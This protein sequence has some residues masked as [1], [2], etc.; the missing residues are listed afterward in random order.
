MG[1]D[2]VENWS[3]GVITALL[4]DRLPDGAAF[5]A[6]N[7]QFRYTGPNNTVFGTRS[8]CS[9]Q[10]GTILA[11]PASSQHFLPLSSGD[12]FHL[13][14]LSNGAVGEMMLKLPPQAASLNRM[15]LS[16]GRTLT[17]LRSSPTVPTSSKQTA[18]I[19]LVSAS[20]NRIVVIGASVR[21]AAVVC[22]RWIPMTLPSAT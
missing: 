13:L 3:Q 6:K 8:G 1:S 17:T 22:C 20:N 10:N 15:I 4:A 21:A 2:I 16:V 9:V 12:N 18:T 14:V 7:T 11:A 19:R 5:V